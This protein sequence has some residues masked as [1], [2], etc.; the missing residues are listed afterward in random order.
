MST[1]AFK[2]YMD[3]FSDKNKV[4]KLREWIGIDILNEDMDAFAVPPDKD[5]RISEGRWKLLV[6][7][8]VNLVNAVGYSNVPEEEA[9]NA[10]RYLFV[11]INC[12]K[13]KLD[14]KAAKKALNIEEYENKYWR[15]QA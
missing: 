13:Y 1:S 9:R 12:M 11:C 2:E 15:K 14:P 5:L 7:H 4:K 6:G 10:V 8:A 3:V